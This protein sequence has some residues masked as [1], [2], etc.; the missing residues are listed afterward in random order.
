MDK[1]SLQSPA[2]INLFLFILGRREDGYHN[3]YSLVQVVDLVDTVE[4]ERSDRTE[5]EFIGTKISGES[6]I[7]KALKKLS[8]YVG[9]K[10]SAKIVVRKRIPAGAGL[11]SGSSNA[12]IALYGLNKIFNLG[13]S[14]EQLREIGASVG[15][16][17]P[18]FLTHGSAIISGRGEIVKEV[19]PPLDYSVVLI[20]PKIRIDTKWA[21]SNVTN[22][23]QPPEELLDEKS[24]EGDNFWQSLSNFDNSFIQVI[25]NNFPSIP[26][27]IDRLKSFG[28]DY[29]SITGS[30]SA[31]FGIF[32]DSTKALNAL[33]EKWDG[34][35][36]LVRP[37]KI[38]L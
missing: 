29:A 14:L 22:Y 2:K 21:Y 37:A 36:Y 8:E 18:L 26:K 20:V 16:D 24:V 30:G 33:M 13:L 7:H 17:V 23:H 3:I 6:T 11:G 19:N 1:I 34:N 9:E 27:D 32:R 25:R 31:Y 4:I 28:A 5:I 38:V 35:T 15:S 12:A 10:L